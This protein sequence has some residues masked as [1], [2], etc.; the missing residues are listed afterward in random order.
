MHAFLRIAVAA[1]FGAVA[2]NGGAG[3]QQ[4]PAPKTRPI[5]EITGT[6]ENSN[7]ASGTIALDRE[8][9]ATLGVSTVQTSTPWT[10]GRPVF[11]GVLMRDLLK[12]V[13]AKGD[14]ITVVALNG[15]KVVLPVAD[16]EKYPVLLAYKMD[17]EVLKVRDKGPLW[18]IYPQDD[19]TELKDQSVHRKWAWQIK[20]FRLE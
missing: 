19:Y 7:T 15:Y 10:D 4:I 3:A 13:G 18:I 6:V 9:L 12:R 8:G 11:E 5:L 1:A 16:F 2:L 17:G 20:E 14:T